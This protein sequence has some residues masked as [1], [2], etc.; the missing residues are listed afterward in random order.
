M[1]LNMNTVGTGTGIGGSSN[2]DEKSMIM[3]PST[4]NPE[5]YGLLAS[6]YIGNYSNM[7]P[8]SDKS[9]NV[10]STH[11]YLQRMFYFK[12]QLWGVSFKVGPTT[13]SKY[14]TVTLYRLSLSSD[15]NTLTGTSV[16]TFNVCRNGCKYYDQ[17]L[18]YP[19]QTYIY[20]IEEDVETYWY[21]GSNRDASSMWFCRFDGTTSE[22]MNKLY[23]NM[24]Y[25]LTDDAWFENSD[26]RINH[27]QMIDPVKE[28]FLLSTY[29]SLY[30]VDL[31]TSPPTVTK[32]DATLDEGSGENYG[33]YSRGLYDIELDRETIN[34]NGWKYTAYFHLSGAYI[35]N[36]HGICH[37][38]WY[39]AS[40]TYGYSAIEFDFID[41][42][43]SF[44]IQNPQIIS[45]DRLIF[46][47]SESG[48]CVVGRGVGWSLHIAANYSDV[49]TMDPTSKNGIYKHYTGSG[50]Q[51]ATLLNVNAGGPGI[52]C[53]SCI[54]RTNNLIYYM[55]YISQSGDTAT[56]AIGVE[57]CVIE[58]MEDASDT[59]YSC[60]SF[61]ANKGDIIYCSSPITSY[62]LSSSST[63]TTISANSKK[64]KIP[65]DGSVVARSDYT[66]PSFRSTWVLLDKYGNTK[67][68]KCDILSNTSIH[69]NFIAGMTVQNVSITQN[70]EQTIT[71]DDIS[72]TGLL[73]D[74]KGV[75]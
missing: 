48:T 39:Q 52:G 49:L 13:G 64:F 6:Y 12:K 60:I 26:M 15:R 61:I 63:W 65:V 25:T 10:I 71:V 29:K 11:P 14:E 8:E 16:L 51:S 20:Y 36:G 58:Y 74:M 22:R 27:F 68:I 73:I 18:I 31:S 34:S 75:H 53:V 43:T 45:S 17:I 4:I 42:G 70:G 32:M 46:N 56:C 67:Y 44:T 21:Q 54:D 7:L 19:G 62:K 59:P 33:Y 23:S 24:E 3:R 66:D 35:I 28:V 72:S 40:T 38:A 2:S 57:P 9:F 50:V 55:G 37:G 1:P 5:Y 30:K 47:P 41:N 69:G